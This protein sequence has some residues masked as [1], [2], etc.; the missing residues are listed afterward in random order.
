LVSK[1]GDEIIEIDWSTDTTKGGLFGQELIKEK[2]ELLKKISE[3]QKNFFSAN[4]KS[5]ERLKKQIRKLKLDILG[6]QLAYMIETK[7]TS[8]DSNS[9]KKPSKKQTEA[10][11]ETEGWN[12]AI[13]E[14]N[15]LKKN[16][17]PFEHFDWKLDF[18]EILNPLVNES[19]GFDIVIGNP[20]Y[21]VSI[22]GDYRK[23][24]LNT[25][26]KVPDYEI[27]YF[28]IEKAYELVKS[29]GML[30][31]IVP[32]TF[33]FNTFASSYRIDLF[34]KWCLTEIL[35]CTQFNIFQTATVRNT[36]NTWKKGKSDKVGYRKTKGQE[37]FNDLI[38]KE[39]VSLPKAELLEMNQNWGLAFM[40][41]KI[42][43]ELVSKIKNNRIQL[44]TLYPEI[45]QG[46]IAYDK[47]RG[48]SKEII[49]SRAYHY[50]SFDKPSLKKW[51]WGA[52][53]TK[54]K[55]EW[56]NQE[57]IDYCDGI[58]NP[59]DSKYFIGERLL[60]REITNPSIFAG[61][62]NEEFYNDPALL[63]IKSNENYSVK[64]LAAIINS[65]LAT[66]FHFN[67]SPKATKGAFPKILIQDLKEFP[68]PKTKNIEPF[69]DLVEYILFL[70]SNKNILTHTDNDSISA[71]IESILDMMVYELYFTEHMKE[72]GVNV[73]DFIQ[74]K[75]FTEVTTNE[76]KTEI[77]KSFYEWFQ[78]PENAVRQRI[79][80]IETRSPNVLAL[81][82]S[83]TI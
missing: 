16:D 31:Y 13:K 70:K 36:I 23:A 12:R 56:N 47:Y 67:H 59:R 74:P 20:P 69:E 73:L 53:V 30:S 18:P 32:N 71:H 17:K 37:N 33:L 44:S 65:S 19:A 35:D 28:F 24:V 64:Y 79:L 68:L 77:I 51:L 26:N 1:F 72:K 48:Q 82:N 52:D 4:N 10:W 45:S 2:I 50:K 76:Q 22:K 39:R 66:F 57:Y 5:K 11:L 58:A 49:K 38:R 63:I 15:T 3:T 83:S 55:V 25:L 61:I 6:N 40:L 46:L 29:E 21:G 8:L 78:E 62:T 27:Y 60:V 9:T 41:D 54:Y 81:I 34:E 75:S 14:I 7:G 80:L 43:V 42:N